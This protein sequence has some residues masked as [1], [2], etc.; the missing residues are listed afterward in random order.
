[1]GSCC[2]LPIP[3][4]FQASMNDCALTE[5]NLLQKDLFRRLERSDLSLVCAESGLPVG[6]DENA[7]DT[8]P[9]MRGTGGTHVVVETGATRHFTQ[10]DLG[11]FRFGCAVTKPEISTQC[12]GRVGK[13][14]PEACSFSVLH[15][16]LKRR[17][18][19]P[20]LSRSLPDWASRLDWRRAGAPMRRCGPVRASSARR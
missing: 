5:G 18:L 8:G 4:L 11:T 6:H 16:T 13:V 12:A 15:R 14:Q 1:M 10:M 2:F 7:A 19:L 20:W 9:K 17:W 3:G